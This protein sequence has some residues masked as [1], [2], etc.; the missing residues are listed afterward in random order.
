MIKTLKSSSQ[1]S[2]TRD[3]ISLYKKCTVFQVKFGPAESIKYKNTLRVSFNFNSTVYWGDGTSS[4]FPNI[5]PTTGYNF[6][7]KYS[8]EFILKNPIITIICQG[9][10]IYIEASHPT[11]YNPLGSALLYRVEHLSDEIKSAVGLFSYAK[12]LT[13]IPEHIFDNTQIKNFE[14]C[15]YKSGIE[16][17][18]EKLFNFAEKDATFI[19]TF[20]ECKN[21]TKSNLIFSG[22]NSQSFDEFTCLFENCDNLKTV[23]ADMFKFVNA[24]ASF[25]ETF[26]GCKTITI[27][28]DFLD[29]QNKPDIF[30]MFANCA[31][32]VDDF[33]KDA[34]RISLDLFANIDLS[35]DYPTIFEDSV[36]EKEKSKFIEAERSDRSKFSFLF[37]TGRMQFSHLTNMQ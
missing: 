5:S 28:K 1:T 3:A 15:F 22:Q 9:Y 33:L 25:W 13:E 18:P 12:N 23:N 7:H 24:N 32:T 10:P 14:Q 4:K 8:D 27:P 19:R 29:S 36:S 2:L 34:P 16:S 21:L 20:A 26:S 11:I 17:V 31:F 30:R 35:I 37:K 6:E